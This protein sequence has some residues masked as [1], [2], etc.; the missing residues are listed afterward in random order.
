MADVSIRQLDATISNKDV[1]IEIK[2]SSGKL[3]TLLISRGNIEWVPSGNYVNKKRL[4]W[5]KFADLMIENG[6][7][8]QIASPAKKKAKSAKKAIKSKNH[9]GR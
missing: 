6:R 3:G 2:D 8:V 1:E 5:K 4:R 7:D 9:N